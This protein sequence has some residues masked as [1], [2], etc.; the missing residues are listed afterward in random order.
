MATP[1]SE[2]SRA[3]ERARV[4]V[5]ELQRAA[6]ARYLELPTAGMAAISVTSCTSHSCNTRVAA[7]DI[8]APQ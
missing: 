3:L 5:L 7:A 8:A 4:E 2:E 1:P 6:L